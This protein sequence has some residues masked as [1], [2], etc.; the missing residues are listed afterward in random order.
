[1]TEYRCLEKIKAGNLL[2]DEE[3]AEQQPLAIENGD[4]KP[5]VDDGADENNIVAIPAKPLTT[6]DIAELKD[7]K[8]KKL[9]INA[10]KKE[11]KHYIEQSWS[12]SLITKKEKEWRLEDLEEN[13]DDLFY[14]TKARELEIRLGFYNYE[15]PTTDRNKES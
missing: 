7:A 11:I 12:D 9:M 8:F 5:E 1:M 4:V 6:Q 3:I 2:N 10:K 13:A 15:A 14:P